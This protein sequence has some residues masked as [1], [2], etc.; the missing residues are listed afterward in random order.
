MHT[1]RQATMGAHSYIQTQLFPLKYPR[2]LESLNASGIINIPKKLQR[3]LGKNVLSRPSAILQNGFTVKLVP[4]WASRVWKEA[5]KRVAPSWSWKG[6]SAP[7]HWPCD[8]IC[9]IKNDGLEHA[10][11]GFLTSSGSL[12]LKCYCWEKAIIKKL[13]LKLPFKLSECVF[14]FVCICS[15]LLIL[16]Y[17]SMCFHFF[18]W[19]N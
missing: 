9:D 13:K 7:R 18:Q 15:N 4:C 3:S 14:V 8:D 19:F 12:C 16:L 2:V 5:I 10:Q 6:K 17:A 11:P 1:R